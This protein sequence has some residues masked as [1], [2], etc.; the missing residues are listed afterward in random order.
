MAQAEDAR[1]PQPQAP[2]EAHQIVEIGRGLPDEWDDVFAW[3]Y[4]P[5]FW[6]IGCG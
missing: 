3:S 5:R 1:S 4:G 6:N 2:I